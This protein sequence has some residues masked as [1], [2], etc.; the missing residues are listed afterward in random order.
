MVKEDG[1]KK[2]DKRRESRGVLKEEEAGGIRN[3]L[4]VSGQGLDIG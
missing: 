1:G 2:A 4:W 3:G